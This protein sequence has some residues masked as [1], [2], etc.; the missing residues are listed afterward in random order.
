[1]VDHGPSF[2][3]R[4]VI[5]IYDD[6]FLRNTLC[7]NRT[8][9]DVKGNTFGGLLPGYPASGPKSEI[10]VTLVYNLPTKRSIEIIYNMC[11]FAAPE[12]QTVV[13]KTLKKLF[14]F[15]GAAPRP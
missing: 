2:N 6:T 12:H 8:D 13:L 3:A 14:N 11:G 10:P 1:M 9:F 5:W 7:R 4:Y 15:W